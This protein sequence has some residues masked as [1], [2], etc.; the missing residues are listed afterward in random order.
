MS[1]IF[2]NPESAVIKNEAE[3]IKDIQNKIS[4]IDA[5][6]WEER[7]VPLE[8]SS[9]G[10]DLVFFSSGDSIMKMQ[11]NIFWDA[12]ELEELY[13]FQNRE[14]IALRTRAT[15]FVRD[16]KMGD[17]V[18]DQKNM[19]ET[20]NYFFEKSLLWEENWTIKERKNKEK[21]VFDRLSKLLKKQAK[22][23]DQSQALMIDFA[24]QLWMLEGQLNRGEFSRNDTDGNLIPIRS[25]S[26]E[27]EAIEN[28]WVLHDQFF[29]D[30]E[31]SMENSRNEGMYQG[32]V[33]YFKN[34]IACLFQQEINTEWLNEQEIEDWKNGNIDYEKTQT[35]PSNIIISCG[36]IPEN[37]LNLDSLEI[38]D[39][40]AG[41][42]LQ[43]KWE[44]PDSKYFTLAGKI[45]IK[46]TLSRNNG[47][48]W[49]PWIDFSPQTTTLLK[50]NH[51][52]DTF[53]LHLFRGRIKDTG[54]IDQQTKEILKKGE[55]ILVE[56][57]LIQLK[58]VGWFESEYIN[59][60]AIGAYKILED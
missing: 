37:I 29:W 14:L 34:G 55:E 58:H 13:Y 6:E 42:T 24:S 11:T 32:E 39:D 21:A 25:W 15:P 41:L 12:G 45:K 26:I 2:K 52:D 48:L 40:L 10:G 56:I 53:L 20:W 50:I 4:T 22:N 47:E 44:T 46:G 28:P 59:E 38:G 35:P 49:E 43:D 7:L 16:E 30:W 5:Q 23:P 36:K 27:K 19:K 8:E 9:E 57:E 60:L 3:I 51:P 54:I 1:W 17:K 18:L 33:G 31:I